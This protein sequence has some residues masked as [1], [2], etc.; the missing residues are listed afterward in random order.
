MSATAVA[1]LREAAGGGNPEAAAAARLALQILYLECTQTAGRAL[2]VRIRRVCI[3][4]FRKLRGPV[5]LDGLGDGLTV[6]AG[7][8]EE[9]K[10]TVL[11]AIRA[12]LFCR[13]RANGEYVDA[14]AP[15]G[16]DG[17]RPVVEL[18]FAINGGAYRLRKAFCRK[19]HEAVLTAGGRLQG[20]CCRGGA[21]P[22]PRL[23]GGA[24]GGDEAGRAR[25]LGAV[26]GQPGHRL[27]APQACWRRGPCHAFR[28]T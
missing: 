18:D 25:G 5:R 24:E 7:D 12:A 13:H 9:G 14:L 1:R 20:R 10:S 15:F 28:R 2:T 3:E 19:P 21:V 23:G 4:D 26:L 22:H 17:A 6:V 11:E 8:N 16:C 27:R